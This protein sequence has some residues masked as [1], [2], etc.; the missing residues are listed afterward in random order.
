MRGRVLL[1]VVAVCF[2]CVHVVLNG[3]IHAYVSCVLS[4]LNMCTSWLKKISCA[5]LVLRGA[6]HSARY[7]PLFFRCCRPPPTSCPDHRQHTAAY[8]NSSSSSTLPLSRI[9][10][11][12]SFRCRSAESI[13]SQEIEEVRGRGKHQPAVS[14]LF[15]YL[16]S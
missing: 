7:V 10:Q 9:F 3:V 16:I 2:W 12:P 14:V 11:L 8:Y 5:L 1:L 4:H 13:S 6:E 15:L